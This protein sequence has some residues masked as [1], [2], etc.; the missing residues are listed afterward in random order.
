MKIY[1][2]NY[3]MYMGYSSNS[4][5]NDFFVYDIN[6]NQYLFF[7]DNYHQSIFN[8][9]IFARTFL[10]WPS[11]SLITLSPSSTILTLLPK[12]YSRITLT[13]DCY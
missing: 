7:I 6:I 13:S 3:T 2:L 9:S 11:V 1:F 10:R 8:S 5:T 12:I 4:N